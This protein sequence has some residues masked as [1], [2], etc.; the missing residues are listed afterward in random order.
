MRDYIASSLHI[1]MPYYRMNKRILL[2]LL[3]IAAIS[4][5]WVTGCTTTQGAAKKD[6]PENY[7]Q[8]QP[9][10]YNSETRGFD[11]PWPFGPV[12]DGS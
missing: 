11:R 10:R 4:P 5:L 1:N 8:I 7:L 3:S 2:L 6:P 12:S 9:R